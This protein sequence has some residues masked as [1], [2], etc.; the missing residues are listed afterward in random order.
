MTTADRQNL[1]EALREIEDRIELAKRAPEDMVSY[2]LR[3]LSVALID[4]A[5]EFDV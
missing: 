2:I 3:R 4:L 5:E 1:V